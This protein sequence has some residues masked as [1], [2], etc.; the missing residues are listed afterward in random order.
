M[1]HKLVSRV[2]RRFALQRMFLWDTLGIMTNTFVRLKHLIATIGLN[3]G[4]VIALAREISQNGAIVSI[5][6]L[7]RAELEE[8]E[9]FLNHAGNQCQ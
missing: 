7:R 4:Q 6:Q 9:A 3:Q 5:A 2:N 1:I 8:M